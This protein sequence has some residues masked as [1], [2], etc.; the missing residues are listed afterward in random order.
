MGGEALGDLLPEGE[1][2]LQVLLELG[3]IWFGLPVD[4]GCV[5][6]REGC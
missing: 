1:G 3:G 2:L 4:L 6:H 5:C